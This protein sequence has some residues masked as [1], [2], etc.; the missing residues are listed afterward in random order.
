MVGPNVEAGEK[1]SWVVEGGLWKSSQL[2]GEEGLLISEV[3]VPG[4]EFRDHEFL[5]WK[6]LLELVGEERAVAWRELLKKE[7][8]GE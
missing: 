7:N 3:V 2:E 5:D 6:R 4:F 8:R 1:I